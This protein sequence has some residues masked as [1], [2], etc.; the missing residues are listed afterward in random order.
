MVPMTEPR[1]LERRVARIHGGVRGENTMALKGG[2]S[3][4]K[5]DVRIISLF[6]FFQNSAFYTVL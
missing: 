4:W 1:P 5:M 2:I 3:M 6:S